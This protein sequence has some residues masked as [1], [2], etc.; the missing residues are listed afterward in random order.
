MAEVVSCNIC[1]RLGK[2]PFSVPVPLDHASK[3]MLT[4]HIA[5]H[6]KRGEVGR[7]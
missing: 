4:E 2:P 3:A 5:E 7:E 6:D 1:K